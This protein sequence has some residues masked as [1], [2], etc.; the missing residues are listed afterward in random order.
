VRAAALDGGDHY[1]FVLRLKIVKD[2]PVPNAPP[3]TAVG[4]CKK[5]NITMIWITAHLAQ[6]GID[7]PYF[8]LVKPSEHASGRASYH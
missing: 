3:Q 4:A 1:Y 8:W 6:D 7:L 5:S 2:T